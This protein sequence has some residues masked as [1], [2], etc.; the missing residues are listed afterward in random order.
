V[1]RLVAASICIILLSSP[2]YFAWATRMVYA[3]FPYFF[4][5]MAALLVADEYDR[6]SSTRAKIVWG[7]VFTAAVAASL[8]I[9][10]GTMALLGAMVAI[11]VLTAFKD[12]R[13]ARTRLLKFLPAL[14][15]G[16]AI[17]DGLCRDTQR[18]TST[19]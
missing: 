10:S 6:A 4:T 9:A 2:L 11:V 13:L 15:V 3:C 16:I 17:Q 19:S 18:L 1:P 5:T 7:S 12:R 8:L 14:I